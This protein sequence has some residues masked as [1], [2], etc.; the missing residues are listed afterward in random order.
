R[1]ESGAARGWLPLASLATSGG[2][3]AGRTSVAAR[4]A[5]TARTRDRGTYR[6]AAARR[7]RADAGQPATGPVRRRTFRAGADAAAGRDELRARAPASG[8]AL[9]G[10]RRATGAG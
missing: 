9:A 3:A 8:P 6:A 7:P 1:T 5:S 2:G 4:R 10:D